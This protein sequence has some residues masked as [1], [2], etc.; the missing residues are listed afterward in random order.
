MSEPTTR[1]GHVA[2]IGRPNVG[3]S[4]LMNQLVGRKIAAVVNKPQTT[5]YVT[6]GIVTEGHLQ[7]VFFD[8]PGLHQHANTLIHK[9]LNR[10]A[11]SVFENVDAIV[12][13][14]EAGQWRAEDQHA[15]QRIQRYGIPCLLVVNKIDTVASRERLLPWLQ[16]MQSKHDFVD[17]VPIS[18]RKLSDVKYLLSV[19]GQHVPEGPFVFDEDEITDRS[20]RFI[21]GEMIRETAMK[22]LRDELPHSV[23]VDVESYE[24]DGQLTTI[25]A[26]VWVSRES[27][28]GI[29]IGKQGAQLKAIGT[30]A[31]Q[32]IEKLVGTRVYLKLWVKVQPDWQNDARHLANLGVDKP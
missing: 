30:Q 11:E 3:K 20:L 32:I 12:F 8:T 7:L 27:H 2:L 10:T 6:R 28:K 24:V 18:A 23:A 25:H 21:V 4:T 1:Y 29:V 15:L 22:M 13:L 9:S 26:A 16:E 14:V 19:I 31:R 5:R 17:I